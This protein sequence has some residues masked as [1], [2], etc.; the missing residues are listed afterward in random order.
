M[1]YQAAMVYDGDGQFLGYTLHRI[2]TNT[3]R[4]THLY[5]DDEVE[6]LQNDL[7]RLN[8][9]ADMTRHWPTNDDPDFVALIADETFMPIEYTEEEVVDDEAVQAMLD[10]G[11]LIPERDMHTD[12]VSGNIEWLRPDKIPMVMAKVPV[13]PAAPAARLRKAR[14]TIAL[15]RMKATNET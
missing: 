13:D 1:E 6:Q 5:S 7:G 2:E 14:E 15:R 4:S 3:L 12:P 10:S 8:H 11:E 9:G